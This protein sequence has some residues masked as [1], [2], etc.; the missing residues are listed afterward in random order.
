MANRAS[1]AQG[2]AFLATAT[3][4]FP[5]DALARLDKAVRARA[6][7][8]HHAP[9]FGAVLRALGPSLEEAQRVHLHLTLRGVSSAAVRLGLLGPHEAQRLQHRLAGLLEQVL[10]ACGS[11]GL[12][13]VA[14]PAPQLDLVGAL[15]DRLYA[16]LFSS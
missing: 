4:V 13:E 10:V 3:Q 7:F 8:G 9:L 11:L 5:D 15:H 6:L 1:R 14:Q 2:R 16:R 12:D